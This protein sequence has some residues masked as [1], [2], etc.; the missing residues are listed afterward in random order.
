METPPA[1]GFWIRAGAALIDFVL[2]AL[3]QRSFVAAGRVIRGVWIF[4][5]W[6]AN[7]LVSLFTL[8]FAVLYA[9]A[10]HA[11][12]GQ[13]IGKLLV[14]VRVVVL[15]G[16]PPAVGQSLLRTLAYFLSM[17]PLGLGFVMAGLRH[18][19]RALHDLVAGTRV[20][21]VVTRVAPPPVTVESSVAPPTESAT[22]EIPPP[23][24]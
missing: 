15:P 21:R 4:D 18:D 8:T 16:A 9:T 24:G 6:G 19:R 20:E 11:A 12:Q 7:F 5:A 14:G 17:A 13:T 22:S 3:V 2:F 10:L 1:A 23:V